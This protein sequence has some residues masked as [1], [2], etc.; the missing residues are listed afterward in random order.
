MKLSAMAVCSL[1]A[2]SISATPA[3]AFGGMTFDVISL[4]S[5]LVTRRDGQN[6][7][8]RAGKSGRQPFVVEL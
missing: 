5:P 8:K 4:D 2:L 1:L 6:F 7:V 3:P